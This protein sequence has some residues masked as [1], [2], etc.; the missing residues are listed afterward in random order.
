M[1]L[2]VRINKDKDRFGE[3]NITPDFLDQLYEK[4]KGR[5]F[6]TKLPFTDPTK[7]SIDR[8]DSSKSYT[9]DNVVLTTININ[10]MKSD[11]P[12]SEFINICKQIAAAN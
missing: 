6:Y 1:K 4:Q 3:C 7:I 2:K 8:I 11:L 9:T 10:T 5:E 12:V